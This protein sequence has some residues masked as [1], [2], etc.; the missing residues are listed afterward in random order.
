MASSP[1]TLRAAAA[2]LVLAAPGVAQGAAWSLAPG[3][4]ALYDRVHTRELRAA[5]TT[6]GAEPRPVHSHALPAPHNGGVLFHAELDGARRTPTE[7]PRTLLQILPRLAFDLRTFKRGRLREAFDGVHPLGTVEVRGEGGKPDEG[8]A[9][10]LQLDLRTTE[11]GRGEGSGHELAATLIVQRRFDAARG[12]VTGFTATLEGTLAQPRD[13]AIETVTLR[14]VETWSF[15]ELADADTPRLRERVGLAIQ[16]GVAA[17][18]AEVAGQAARLADTDP[19]AGQGHAVDH[20]AGELAL[21]VLTLI[22][23][24]TPRDDEVVQAACDAL[25]ARPLRDSYTLGVALMA[26][27]ALYADPNERDNLVSG[28]LERP[29][30]RT[31]TDAD[32]AL[33]TQWVERLLANRD[34]RVDWSYTSRWTYTGGE[35][36][37]NSNSQYALLGLYSAQLCGVAIPATVWWSASKHF[38][39][40]QCPSEGSQPLSLATRRQVEAGGSTRGTL[41]RIDARGWSYTYANSPAYGSM[42]SAG[43]A[44][45]TICLAG[46]RDAGVRGG[47][48]VAAIHAG[49]R[50][51]W[52]WFA[53]NFR[54]R[55]NPGPAA[56]HA[57]WRYYY[58]YGLERACELSQIARVGDRDWYFEGASILLEMQ[59]ENGRFANGSFADQCFAVLFLK[60]ASLPVFTGR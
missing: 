20:Q 24:G 33:M 5:T 42:T 34:T 37:D 48:Q 17:I 50:G 3:Q 8:G 4:A 43:I 58:L 7:A 57:N 49:I 22:K 14:V 16:R 39:D 47:P 9:Q 11:R 6:A 28:R 44:G 23:G 30:P 10:E 38:L 40:Q 51:G 15:R 59:D 60:K 12:L 25:R 54:T 27:E 53:R 1:Q 36:F 35:A 45:L 32:R 29:Q 52:A 18:R 46:L 19:P 2:A 26:F 13:Q 21:G 31:P 55:D 56:Q 41:G